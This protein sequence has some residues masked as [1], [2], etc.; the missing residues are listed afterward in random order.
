[1]HR[2]LLAG[3]VDDD[4]L[5]SLGGCVSPR[6]RFMLLTNDHFIRESD[7]LQSLIRAKPA[8]G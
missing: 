7:S 5:S 1:M 4:V 6:I 2:V 8:R 3:K